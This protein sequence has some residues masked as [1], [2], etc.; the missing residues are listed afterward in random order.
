MRIYLTGFMGVGKTTVGRCLASRL[1]VDF[2]DLDAEIERDAGLS[3][4]EIFAR[5]G[6]PAFR[7]RE[8]KALRS[9]SER[10]ALVVATGGGVPLTE[11]NRE[12]MSRDGFSIWLDVPLVAVLERIGTA[13]WE[14][15]P[16]LENRHQAQSLYQSRRP[17]YEGAD[18]RISLHG[19]ESPEEVSERIVGE[20]QG[21]GGLCCAT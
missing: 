13:A 6:E 17:A 21:L 9:A 7:D 11:R 10:S 20:L 16:L 15:R 3:I 5:E 14:G 1:G 19:N 12:W 4:T 18:L 8:Y 2:L